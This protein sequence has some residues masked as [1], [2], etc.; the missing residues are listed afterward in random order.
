MKKVSRVEL[1][2]TL[3]QEL[4]YKRFIHT[5]SV[6][7]TASSLA[8]CYG[9]DLEKA[10]TAG[11]LHDCAKCM[12]VRK[13]QKVCEKAGL[14]VSSFE[15]DSA[16]LLHSKAGSVLAAEKYG[17]T[18]PDM[19]NAIRYHTTG[20]PGMSLLEKIIF[21]ADYIEPGRFTA[22]N[23]PLIRRLAFSDID[24]ALMKILYDTLVY[25]NSTGLVVDPM[26]QKTYDYYKQIFEE[27]T[28]YD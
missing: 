15:A 27:K 14:T 4:S 12:D 16:S 2:K 18:D 8:M 7:G 26:T 22:K 13:M 10:E 1:I 5:L 28:I 20:R 23:L 25:L 19:I 9:A 6:A 3:E 17:I 21:V 11:L 24:E